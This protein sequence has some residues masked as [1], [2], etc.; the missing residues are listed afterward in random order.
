[1]GCSFPKSAIEVRQELSFLDMTVRQIEY[2]NSLYGTDVPLILMNSFMTHETTVKLIRK[3][4]S[5]NLTIHTFL[6]NCYPRIVKD[7]LLPLPTSQFSPSSTH[8]WYPPGHGD[9]YYSLFTSGMSVL[10]DRLYIYLYPCI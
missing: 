5:H 2:L 7:T 1:M 6:Q 3:Y 8:E 10:V 9:V 4:H